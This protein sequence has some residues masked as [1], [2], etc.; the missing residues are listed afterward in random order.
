MKLLISGLKLSSM[1][2]EK[3]YSHN[4]NFNVLNVTAYF[5]KKKD[6]RFGIRLSSNPCLF[7]IRG[8][9]FTSVNFKLFAKKLE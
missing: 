9:A 3:N 8:V 7:L 1:H 4:N 5:F 2:G 6:Q